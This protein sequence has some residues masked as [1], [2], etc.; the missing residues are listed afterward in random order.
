MARLNFSKRF[1]LVE[2]FRNVGKNYVQCI[3][4][5]KT[6]HR[7]QKGE[8]LF[9]VSIHHMHHYLRMLLTQIK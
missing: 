7:H 9:W 6:I 3:N 4:M 5:F 8:D 1:C 2:S